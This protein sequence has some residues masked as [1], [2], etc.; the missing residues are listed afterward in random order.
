[1]RHY[2][3]RAPYVRVRFEPGGEELNGITLAAADF[4]DMRGYADIWALPAAARPFVVPADPPD[5]AARIA[6]V[7]TFKVPRIE[8]HQNPPWLEPQGGFV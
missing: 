8:P 4:T 3:D 2:A 5:G 6:T 1:V 7:V